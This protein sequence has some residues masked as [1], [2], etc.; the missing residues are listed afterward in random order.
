[1]TRSRTANEA[2]QRI[3]DF[4]PESDA[5]KEFELHARV[6]I[7][8]AA[9]GSQEVTSVLPP[10]QPAVQPSRRHTRPPAPPA[11]PSR[12][13]VPDAPT[14]LAPQSGTPDTAQVHSSAATIDDGFA[15]EVEQRLA[16]ALGP[17]A[18][19]LVKRARPRAG[20]HAELVKLLAA[21]L[22]DDDER[23]RFTRGLL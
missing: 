2:I 13:V 5:R 17:I 10:P 18:T 23:A 7:K 12:P 20:S 4:I 22:D 8:A 6:V 9:R 1:M 14:E 16:E 19:M 11:P 15:G 3:S 21:E